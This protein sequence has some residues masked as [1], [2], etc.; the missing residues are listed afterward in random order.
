LLDHPSNVCKRR[1]IFAGNARNNKPAS[2]SLTTQTGGC[3][4]AVW[5]GNSSGVS[6]AQWRGIVDVSGH[7]HSAAAPDKAT[8]AV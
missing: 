4:A 5:K 6:K 8:A 2:L 1:V 7:C 3:H